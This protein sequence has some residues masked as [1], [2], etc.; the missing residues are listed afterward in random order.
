MAS[1]GT[2]QYRRK[3][4][5]PAELLLVIKELLDPS[6]LRTHACYYL[7]SPRVA[8]LYDSV[9]DPDAFWKLACWN[10][11]IGAGLSRLENLPQEIWSDFDGLTWKNIALDCIVRDGF[12]R[13]P[14]CG[15]VLLEYNRESMRNIA[16]EVIPFQPYDSLNHEDYVAILS[17]RLFGD[18]EFKRDRNIFA[19]ETTPVE[20]DAHL[21][22]PGAP[23]R[24]IDIPGYK[25]LPDDYPGLYLTDHPLAARSFATCAPVSTMMLLPI[26]GHWLVDHGKI[27]LSRPI[28][29]LDVL[30]VVHK[31]LDKRLDVDELCQHMSF[32]D[33]CIPEEWPHAEAFR[34]ARTIRSMLSVCPMKE[35]EYEETDDDGAVLSLE[36]M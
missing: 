15:E 3:L 8:A 4:D 31:D 21:R 11:G 28:T 9:Q 35:L 20:R 12:C 6:D 36:L 19:I 16:G 17:H 1:P 27:Q 7:S 18:I 23:A 25:S 10:C 13:H 30:E 5:F 33:Q 2:L 24:R 34:V 22:T 26:M 32:H 29:V 14:R